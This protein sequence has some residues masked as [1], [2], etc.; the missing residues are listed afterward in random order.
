MTLNIYALPLIVSW[1]VLSIIALYTSK[2]KKSS[3]TSYFSLLLLFTG[4]YSLFYAFEI[5]SATAEDIFMFRKLESIGAAWIPGFFLLFSLSYTG[6]KKQLSISEIV[7]ILIIPLISVILIFT[8]DFHHLYYSEIQVDTK[9]FVPLLII[10]YQAWHWVQ[11]VYAMICIFLSIAILSN[12][13]LGSSPAFRKQTGIV[14]VG[15]MVPFFTLGATLSKILSPGLDPFP[16]SLI[17]SSFLVFIGL[18]RYGLLDLSPLARSLLFENIMEG[19]IVFDSHSR[20]VDYNKKATTYMGINVMDIG[21]AAPEVFSS[22]P[23]LLGH[24]NDQDQQNNIQVK[25]NDGEK[26]LWLNIEFLPLYDEHNE[27][28]GQMLLL[29]DITERKNS[30]EELLNTNRQ[31][32]AAITHA[33]KM[34]A[35]AE[36]ANKAKSEFLASMSH[37]L[38]T[39]LNGVIGFSD[40]LMQTGLT[41]SQYQYVKAVNTSAN[42]L[43][44][45][46]NDVLDFSKIEAGKLELYP[47]KT[48]LIELSEQVIDLVKYKAHEKKLE[49][50]LNISSDFS[51]NIFADKLRL[52]QVMVNLLGNAIKFTE[53]GE[54]ELEIEASNNLDK[55]NEIE[56][57]FSVRDSGIGISKENHTKIFES[58]SQA[59]GSITRKFGGTGLGLAI[60]NKLLH[61]MGSQLE[62]DSEPGKGSKFYFTVRFPVEKGKSID[63]KDLNIHNALILDDNSTNCSILQNILKKKGIQTDVAISAAEAFEMLN[64]EKKYDLIIVDYHMPAMDGLEFV[65][66]IREKFHSGLNKQKIIFLYN[67]NDGPQMLDELK[68]LGVHSHLVKPV[69]V[70]ELFEVF[71]KLSSSEDKHKENIEEMKT[72]LAI[73]AQNRI[74]SIMIADDNETNI[75]LA[76]A[77]VSKLLAGANIL[78]ARDGNEALELFKKNIPDL[79][80][81][82]IQMPG[83]SGYETA[84]AIRNFEV[85]GKSHVPIIALTAGTVKGEMERCKQAGMDD[86]ITKP[87]IAGTIQSVLQKWLVDRGSSEECRDNKCHPVHFDKRLLMENLGNNEELINTLVTTALSSLSKNLDKLTIAFS[88]KN[89]Q[90]VKRCAHQIKG[91]ALNVGFNILAELSE[92]VETAIELDDIKTSNLLENMKY[93][94]EILK[95]DIDVLPKN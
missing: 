18:T 55:T 60:S 53:N 2:V 72:P 25:R 21:K 29:S 89:A 8:N 38:R 16:F 32:E 24:E 41:D 28:K 49:L 92:Q 12:M 33:N 86:Y 4:V 17:F 22:W 80:L 20:I 27:R 54:V 81:M 11:Q 43:L 61:Q 56:L 70:T 59:D 5:S 26:T 73:Y 74:Y 47:E 67:S 30:Q 46:I 42:S 65:R 9:G 62:L 76:S 82:D 84:M 44:D 10:K 51:Y 94:V 95:H 45:L 85:N 83:M 31:L 7:S 87:V 19:A 13:W 57:T 93:E 78:K 48:N 35:E 36:K 68:E 91:T 1:L 40:L 37:E 58:F 15:F 69:K 66:C 23:E 34:T 6:R 64:K 52:R 77:I 39:P 71:D 50:L 75:M 79:V 88:E 63:N 14:I 90:E 3:G